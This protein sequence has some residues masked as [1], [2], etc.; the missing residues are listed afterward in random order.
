MAE[1]LVL[2]VFLDQQD[3]G[4]SS[5]LGAV[6]FLILEGI[7][8]FILSPNLWVLNGRKGPPCAV[9]NTRIDSKETLSYGLSNLTL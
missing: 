7:F 9:N 2:T 1:S 5:L 6:L 3:I 4:G 8:C